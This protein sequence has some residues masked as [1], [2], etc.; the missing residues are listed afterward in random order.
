MRRRGEPLDAAL[1]HA[2]SLARPR[3]PTHTH[4]P[5]PTHP[6]HPPSPQHAEQCAQAVQ[7]YSSLGKCDEEDDYEGGWTTHPIAADALSLGNAPWNTNDAI[8]LSDAP[9]LTADECE[10]IR[11]SAAKHGEANGWGSRYTYAESSLECN[12]ADVPVARI[13]LDKILT[14][15]LLPLCAEKFPDLDANR[16]RVYNALVIKYDGAS[17]R[18]AM[19]EHNDFGLLTFNIALNDPAEYTGGGTWFQA[20]GET[21]RPTGEGHGVLHASPLSHCGVPI[22]EGER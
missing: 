14:T 11:T 16:L 7:V 9:L 17:A 21:L 10:A 19:P 2:S 15:T 20:A 12:V 22:T 8:L 3:P 6:T 4:P 13:V 5:T 1:H 18:N